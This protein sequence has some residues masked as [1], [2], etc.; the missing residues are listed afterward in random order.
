MKSSLW[1][2]T[3]FRSP[4]RTIVTWVLLLAAAFQFTLSLTDYV[5]TRR[6][7]H[8]AK[9]S[10]KGV[11]SIEHSPAL[12]PN[13]PG[14]NAGTNLFLM[15]DPTGPGT[16]IEQYDNARYHATPI[17]DAE[18]AAVEQSILP[19][20]AGIEVRT[21][22]AG[23]SDYIRKEGISSSGS[24]LYYKDRL[25]LEA[26]VAAVDQAT[27]IVFWLVSPG[28][29]STCDK[30][31][32]CVLTLEDIRL[33]A[34]ESAPLEMRGGKEVFVIAASEAYR[35]R[36]Y[37]WMYLNCVFFKN[38]LYAEDL[39][40]LEVG[41]RY[42]FVVRTISGN[43]W[44]SQ[45][46]DSIR[47]I[48]SFGDD[49]LLD[50]WPYFTDITDLP[51]N[52]LEGED[53]AALR[54]LIQVTNDDWHTLDVV[55]AGDMSVIRRATDLRLTPVQGRFL[56]PE[57]RETPVCVVNEDFAAANG[58]SLGDTLRLKLGDY[59]MEQH[60]S[61]GAV[62]STRGRYAE[63]WTEQEFTIIGTW[64]DV[65][66]GNYL[67]EDYIWAYS[68][69]TV[70]VPSSYT[71]EGATK[72]TA[73]YPGDITLLIDADAMGDFV[74]NTLPALQEAGWIT[75]W[76]DRGWPQMEEELNQVS[77]T[78]LYKLLAFG[79]ATLLVIALTVYLFVARRSRDYAILRAMGMDRRHSGRSLLIPLLCLT[80]AAV[81]PGVAAALIWYGRSGAVT[82]MPAISVVILPAV[83]MLAAL[84][85]VTRMG[86]IS[87]LLLIQAGVKK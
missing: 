10:M 70:F 11:L 42:V 65:N 71:P 26:T 60:V 39:T 66:Q 35:D 62:A 76:N 77:Q 28:Q 14:N 46:T 73:Y 74:E 43:G 84:V 58:L 8:E 55:Y 33:L 9:A 2:K 32:S 6:G 45:D 59:P 37:I 36:P 52:Y 21:M 7:L 80:L 27:D 16:G 57:D 53:F 25:V 34:G 51:G 44:N 75:Y 87:P 49:T 41:R 12:D 24:S 78:S 68:D 48:L 56:E 17:T 4:V 30:E 63:N 54:E 23:I 67:T 38:R 79:A 20:L 29:G 50:W 47:P 40:G 61:L 83:T 72:R 64:R 31:A 13:A 5:S 22:T 19:S 81:I 86:R 18:L 1:I 82:L 85:L 15:Y 69:S 3:L